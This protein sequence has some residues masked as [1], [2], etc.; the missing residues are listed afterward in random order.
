MTSLPKVFPSSFLVTTSKALV[1]SSKALVTRS[2]A[3]VPSSVALVTTSKA[4]VTTSMDFNGPLSG[5][6]VQRA[7]FFQARKYKTS[8]LT[9]I[10]CLFAEVVENRTILDEPQLG[11]EVAMFSV[12]TCK[13]D[14][15]FLLKTRTCFSAVARI[16]RFLQFSKSLL[17][18]TRGVLLRQHILC[19][20]DHL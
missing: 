19:V 11:L 1:T 2:D 6:S 20:V 3:L 10:V 12:S 9:L 16:P 4:P 18:K 8:A 13:L 14:P 7:R 17:V 5:S 15:D